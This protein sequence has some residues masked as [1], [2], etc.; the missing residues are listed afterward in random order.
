MDIFIPTSKKKDAIV[1]PLSMV[2]WVT[3]EAQQVSK[4]LCNGYPQTQD[5]WREPTP[6]SYEGWNNY[7]GFK[8]IYNFCQ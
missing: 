7:F 5:E 3:N 8:R 6:E 4:I 1:G 2:T